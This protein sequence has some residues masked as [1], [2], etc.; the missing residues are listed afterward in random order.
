M[1]TLDV[2]SSRWIYA[3]SQMTDYICRGEEL[4]DYNLLDYFTETYEA[5]IK[6]RDRLEENDEMDTNQHCKH[7]QRNVQIQYRLDHP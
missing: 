2:D 3:K 4:E 5:E 1:I 7:C 6:A